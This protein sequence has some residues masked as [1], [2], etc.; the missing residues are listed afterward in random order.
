MTQANIKNKQDLLDLLE[1]IGR[2]L[3]NPKTVNIN[4]A[5]VFY[6][7]AMILLRVYDK[8]IARGELSE[9][10]IHQILSMPDD[11]MKTMLL[12]GETDLPPQWQHMPLSVMLGRAAEI[13]DELL[14]NYVI[15]YNILDLTYGEGKLYT[16]WSK[17]TYKITK[18]D[19]LPTSKDVIQ[20][21]VRTFDYLNKPLWNDKFDAIIYDPPY[22]YGKQKSGIRG[23]MGVWEDY[24]VNWTLDEQM[25]CVRAV[26]QKAPALLE[27]HGVLLVKIM[28]VRVDGKFI[29]NH[30][31]MIDE[32]SKTMELYD[33]RVYIRLIT[34][35]Y[36]LKAKAETI[37][38]FWLI[39]KKKLG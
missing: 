24:H 36:N 8:K 10:E 4:D 13:L 18:C 9:E 19:K 37:H 35:V 7:V 39:F 30:V 31:I 12:V 2:E 1:S 15:G 11:G 16:D 32:I 3:V 38:G 28:D 14:R 6:Q 26:A 23:K 22:R 33:I 25:E 29:L 27:D 34:G 20:A 5:R 17:A 21:D